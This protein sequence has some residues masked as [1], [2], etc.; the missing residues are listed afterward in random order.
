MTLDEFEF[1]LKGLIPAETLKKRREEGTFFLIENGTYRLV[2]GS[3]AVSLGEEYEQLLHGES[4]G[5]FTLSGQVACQGYARGIAKIILGEE[6]FGKLKE[7]EIL[8]TGMTWPEFVPLMKKALAV[9]TNEGGIT[10]HAAIISRE[11]GKPCIIGTKK[12]THVLHDGDL[13]EVRAHHG[14]VRLIQRGS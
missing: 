11:L 9:V 1:T 10:S 3:E 5:E 6:D 2:T 14:T 4:L 13:I 8:V 7:G 12:A